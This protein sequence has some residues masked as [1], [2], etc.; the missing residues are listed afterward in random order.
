MESIKVFLSPE[1]SYNNVPPKITIQRTIIK[2][3]I[4]EAANLTFDKSL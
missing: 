1:A 3:A 2:I 4:I